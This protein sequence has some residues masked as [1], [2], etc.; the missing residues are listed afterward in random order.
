M[1]FIILEKSNEAEATSERTNGTSSS[2][3]TPGPSTSTGEG[4]SSTENAENGESND[5]EENAEEDDGGNLE[6]AWEVLQNAALIFQRQEERGLT[7]LLD[8][9][10]EMAT[11]SIENSNFEI[12]L[13]DLNRAHNTF[14]LLEEADQNDRIL[15]DIHYRMGLC[16]SMIKQYDESM[17]SFQ[18]ASDIFGKLIEIE[19]TKEQNE[20]VL[21]K[22]KDLEETQQE[23]L[24]KIAET[25]GIKT[26]EIERVKSEL[27]KLYGINGSSGSD[28]GAGPS[29]SSS[30]ST[31]K[32]PE[33]DKPKPT[34]I[35]HLI[36]RKK[37]DSEGVECSPAK[38]HAVETSP[39]EKTE[40][41]IYAAETVEK[42]VD[43]NSSVQVAES[44]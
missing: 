26:E 30:K 36:K 41:P 23:I 13:D 18:K 16:Q 3:P 12:A 29:G 33:A 4:T 35:S 34:N 6:V 28:A 31:E 9:Y 20:E 15:A 25:G 1:I 5:S 22:I 37:P 24:N 39:G 40:V 7:K 42:V 8:V 38:K 44:I 17:K 27:A 21:A 43:E 32:S 11:I 19:K 2:D 14:T 10:S